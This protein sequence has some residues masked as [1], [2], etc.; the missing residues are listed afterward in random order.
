MSQPQPTKT[1]FGMYMIRY[2]KNGRFEGFISSGRPNTARVYETIESAVKGTQQMGWFKDRG[3]DLIIVEITELKEVKRVKP[4]KDP[5]K[6]EPV[7]PKLEE[8][9]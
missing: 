2:S 5:K 3:Y 4:N 8:E 9:N 1:G 6:Y 7:F